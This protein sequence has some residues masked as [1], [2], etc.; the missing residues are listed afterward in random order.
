MESFLEKPGRLCALA[1]AILGGCKQ[2][3]TTKD[4]KDHEGIYFLSVS[5]STPGSFLPPRN[6]GEAPAPVEICVIL[7]G[8]PG[9]LT[10]ETESP[11]PTIEV[12]PTFS[13]TAW[14]ILKV[15]LAKGATSNTPMGPFHKMVAARAIS[16]VKAS[17][18]L[19]PISRAIRLAGMWPL[20]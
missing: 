20:V 10:A 16:S 2:A 3:V 1:F 7:S 9:A 12:A 15:P 13:A 6:S 11:P 17:M 14:A 5:A 8:A 19:G 18:V 4:T